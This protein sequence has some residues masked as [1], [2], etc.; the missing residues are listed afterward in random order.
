MTDTTIREI[1]LDQLVESPFNPRRT[2]T[3]IDELAANITAEGRIHQALLVRPITGSEQLEIVFGHR[4]FRAAGVAGLATAPCEVRAM[5][6][7]EARSAQM[8][9][10]L[11]REAMHAFE[12][13][14]GYQALVIA[15][16]V[17]REQIAAQYGMS[18]SHV[19]GRLKLLQAAPQVRQDCL[20]GKFGAEV[21]LL[22]ARLRT[23]ELQ[24]HALD[25]IHKQTSDKLENLSYRDIR[26]MLR[27]RYTLQLDDAPFD[28]TDMLLLPDT[29]ACGECPKRSGNAPEYADLVDEKN[30]SSR[31]VWGRRGTGPNLCTDPDCYAAKSDHARAAKVAA[32]EAKGKTVATPKQTA[33]AFHHYGGLKDTY[34]PLADVKDQ[35]KKAKDKGA[36]PQVITLLDP[37]TQKPIDVVKRADLQA[38]GVQ[39]ERDKQAAKDASKRLKT[40]A[41]V[42]AANAGHKRLLRTVHEAMAGQPITLEALRIVASRLLDVAYE[43]GDDDGQLIDELYGWDRASHRVPLERLDTMD[44]GDMTRLIVECCLL[45][46]VHVYR[47]EQKPEALLTLASALGIDPEAAMQEPAQTP[48]DIP[49]EASPAAK[50]PRKA[51]AATA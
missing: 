34:V 44:A 20:D 33:A 9:E 11:K 47:A 40:A 43:Y 14:E 3:G 4:R 38:A 49:A 42:D 25:H 35:L 18:L 30:G 21:A 2:F 17:T 16:G 28:T 22:F 50:K 19:T 48:A 45:D 27:E 37:K 29:P 46:N 12:E 7:A 36:A 5:S 51:K 23:V 15:H 10:N 26:D 31:F 13:A 1:P 32:L 6:D 8:S 39:N 24:E 41:A